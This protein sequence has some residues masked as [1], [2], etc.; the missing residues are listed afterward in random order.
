MK[1]Y[2]VK[3]YFYIIYSLL[4]LNVS[5]GNGQSKIESKKNIN[6]GTTENKAQE[7]NVFY[8]TDKS[9]LKEVLIFIHGGNWRSGN[10][11]IYSYLGKRFAKKGIV[12][13]VIGYPHEP[14]VTY[15]DMATST[16]LAVLWVQKNIDQYGGNAN[17]IFISGHSAGGHLAAL[18]AIRNEYFDTLKIANPI[19]GVVLIDAAGLDMHD[20]L[21]KENLKKD[22]HYFRV[23]TRN[24]SVW[25][26]ATPLYH[27]R[28]GMPKMLIYQ[29]GKTYPSIKISNEKFIAALKP[30]APKPI[31]HL[32]PN[33][34]HIPMIFQFNNSDNPIFKEII[35]F[36]KE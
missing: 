35:D 22:H 8:P 27:L 31:F 21:K 34:R 17:K 5:T 4:L 23:F 10:K 33:K 15:N 36:M 16:A 24:P 13:V 7:L 18:V 2:T 26:E 30:Y 20:Y 11:S 9:Q 19:K 25:K 12:T 29:G 3:N 28:S 6:Y 1:L 32:Q 14:P